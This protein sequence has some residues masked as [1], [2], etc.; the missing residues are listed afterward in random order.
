MML[1]DKKLIAASFYKIWV[2]REGDGKLV[3]MDE[4][5]LPSEYKNQQFRR[6]MLEIHLQ[7]NGKTVH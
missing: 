4:S 5:V 3:L 2:H 7:L 6:A 1:I